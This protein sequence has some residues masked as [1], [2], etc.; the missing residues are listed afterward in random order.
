MVKGPGM[1]MN[2]V[3]PENTVS[4]SVYRRVIVGLETQ[5]NNVYFSENR[6]YNAS[7]DSWISAEA[8]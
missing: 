3:T 5:I 6:G 1:H 8:S 4:L 2:N 7:L